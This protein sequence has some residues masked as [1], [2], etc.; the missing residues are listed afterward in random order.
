MRFSRRI[1]GLQTAILR[2]NCR[3]ITASKQGFPTNC[4]ALRTR[5]V[6]HRVKAAVHRTTWSVFVYIKL[7]KEVGEGGK[8]VQKKVKHKP[9]CR[10]DEIICLIEG[11]GNEKKYF[12]EQVTTFGNNQE[13]GKFGEWQAHRLK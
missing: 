11:I 2:V 8:R 13:K 4:A 12:D 1:I 3:A 6:T 7:G 10:D 5:A 9:T